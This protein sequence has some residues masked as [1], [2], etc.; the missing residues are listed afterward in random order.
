MQV[1]EVNGAGPIWWWGPAPLKGPEW[2]FLVQVSRAKSDLRRWV[3]RPAPLGTLTCTVGYTDLH[4]WVHRPAPLG[5][6]TCTVGY[7]DLHHP[8]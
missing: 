5:T 1:S 7:T 2:R 4:R 3:H 8:H 6:L